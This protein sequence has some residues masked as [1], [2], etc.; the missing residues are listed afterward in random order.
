V[1]KKFKSYRIGDFH[2]DLAEMRT[3]QSC[4]HRFVGIDRTSKSVV[5]ELLEEVM[6][7]VSTA[8]SRLSPGASPHMD[9]SAESGQLNLKD[10][11]ST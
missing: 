7:A 5:V 3:E 11:G 8:V 1:R 6:T 9:I 2:I 4:L 10:S